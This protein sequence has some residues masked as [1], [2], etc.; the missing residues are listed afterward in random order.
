VLPSFHD[1]KRLILCFCRCLIDARVAGELVVNGTKT[2]PC[3]SDGRWE[4][5][6]T[7]DSQCVAV[8][9]AGGVSRIDTLTVGPLN[10]GVSGPAIAAAA[11]AQREQQRQR[12]QDGEEAALTCESTYV[13]LLVACPEGIDTEIA[14]VDPC[15]QEKVLASA[16]LF[17]PISDDAVA[18]LDCTSAPAIQPCVDRADFDAGFGPCTSYTPGGPNSNFCV[19]D[20]AVPACSECGVC[21]NVASPTASTNTPTAPPTMSPTTAVTTPPP[22]RVAAPT[23]VSVASQNSGVQLSFSISQ[24][25]VAATADAAADAADATSL[26]SGA[27]T[28]S[29]TGGRRNRRQTTPACGDTDCGLLCQVA[30]GN[31][32]LTEA[33]IVL[34]VQRMARLQTSAGASIT[35]RVGA[36]ITQP[37]RASL[38]GNGQPTV[39]DANGDPT[40]A[41]QRCIDTDPA[42]SCR[43]IPNCFE[44]IE[45]RLGMTVEKSFS[46]PLSCENRLWEGQS[47][48]LF[49]NVPGSSGMGMGM[50][51]SPAAIRTNP[52]VVALLDNASGGTTP[53]VPNLATHC[54]GITAAIV[55]G[56]GTGSDGSVPGGGCGRRY[57]RVGSSPRSASSPKSAGAVAETYVCDYVDLTVGC[58]GLHANP[59]KIEMIEACFEVCQ[60]LGPAFCNGYSLDLNPV[61]PTDSDIDTRALFGRCLLFDR[62]LQD[63]ITDYDFASTTPSSTLT[64]KSSPKK[65]PKNRPP[66]TLKL[67]H[68]CHMTSSVVD[69]DAL[70]PYAAQQ[71][72]CEDPIIVLESSA[73]TPKGKSAPQR[74][75]GGLVV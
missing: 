50:G 21:T 16:G 73:P 68:Q 47:T 66:P 6:S 11:Q 25:G 52:T 58:V 53:R 71:D 10:D 14:L 7:N 45:P 15:L 35:D 54:P 72:F 49:E 74:T 51:M 27:P 34:I 41:A 33:D 62:P 20:G 28:S 12:R 70:P 8:G 38:T 63:L 9:G 39:V 61:D 56:Q 2:R 46:I 44:E 17:L 5:S 36:T 60:A 43:V 26:I 13:D 19:S 29:G 4:T 67:F 18:T 48:T 31:P 59:R 40:E 57:V 30:C 64:P 65:S 32:L 75:F 69:V 22:T 23:F 3:G 37:C 42:D 1:S 24:T 55:Q